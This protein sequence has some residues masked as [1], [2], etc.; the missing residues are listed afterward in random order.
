MQCKSRKLLRQLQE[1]LTHLHTHRHADRQQ[2]LPPSPPSLVGLELLK[3]SNRF[4]TEVAH[5]R[6]CFLLLLYP[7][8]LPYS[9]P[10]PT[11]LQL[12]Q[13]VIK[14]CAWAWHIIIQ[15]Q[16]IRPTDCLILS[17]FTRCGRGLRVRV[18][19]TRI[20]RLA[21]ADIFTTL[22]LWCCPPRPPPPPA[23][24]TLTRSCTAWV[25]QQ[26]CSLTLYL[27]LSIAI[28]ATEN[29]LNACNLMEKSLAPA[30]L[31]SPSHSLLHCLRLIQPKLM[32]YECK[33]RLRLH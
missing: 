8:L 28:M 29:V 16:Q 2:S 23:S 6:T 31:L 1:T 9:P 26:P 22:A 15:A 12:R 21:A 20:Y 24:S 27:S 25:A 10:C 11:P 3:V 18:Y 17:P 13:A 30:A 32:H 19:L 5:V 33:L 14:G 4:L 7:P